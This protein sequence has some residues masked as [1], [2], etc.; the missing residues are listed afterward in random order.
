MYRN[1]RECGELII[2]RSDMGTE[3]D[4]RLNPDFCRNCLKDGRFTDTNRHWNNSPETLWAYGAAGALNMG[5]GPG[6]GMGAGGPA[7]F[8]VGVPGPF[9]PTDLME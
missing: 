9:I 2:S 7:W 1:C 5:W 3:A 6:L 8:G 4:G